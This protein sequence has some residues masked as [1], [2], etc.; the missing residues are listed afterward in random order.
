MDI[1]LTEWTFGEAE[2]R[3]VSQPALVV[4]GGDSPKLHPRFEE[5]Y[6][7]LLEWLPSGEG[8]GVPGA[9]HFLQLESAEVSASVASG[10]AEFFRRRP[11]HQ[12]RL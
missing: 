1:G 8:L 4:L 7:L 12:A 11:L 3:R 2:A 9:T 6:R 5:T 10:I